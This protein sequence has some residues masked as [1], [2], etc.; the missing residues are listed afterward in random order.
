M[1]AKPASR[2]RK[3]RPAP[4]PPAAIGLQSSAVEDFSIVGIGASAGGLEAFTQFLQALP[5]DTGMAFVL[6]QHLEPSHTSLLSE[7]LTRTTT[8]AV[9][10]VRNGMAIAPNCVYVI[11][12]NTRMTLAD[13]HL[14]LE[15]RQRTQGKHL[16]I[17][18]F[19]TSLATECG[20]QAIAIVLSGSGDDGAIGIAAVKAAGG[21]TFA[22]TPTSAEFPTMPQN[23]IATGQVDFVLPPVGIAAELRRISHDPELVRSP[24]QES[25]AIVLVPNV[26]PPAS[27]SQ[28]FALLRNA[29]GV[30]FTHYKQ[31]TLRRRITRRMALCH[32]DQID[33][34]V[35][36]LHDHPIEV[37]SLYHDILINVTSFFREPASFEALKIQVFPQ[38]L[39]DQPGDGPIRIWIP[40][41]ATGEEAYSMAISLLE[42][43]ADQGIQ[44]TIQIFATDISEVA[45][46]EA[47]LG[48]YPQSRLADVSPERL[49][50]FFVPTDGGHQISKAVRELCVFACQDLTSD[51]PFSRLDLISCRNVLIY[52]EP[53]LQKKVMPIF[54]YAL[55]P[56]GYLIL[57]SSESI[58][59]FADLFAIADKK[60]RIYSRKSS[61][62]RLNFSFTSSQSAIAPL[63]PSGPLLTAAWSDRSLTQAADQIV[64][65][66]YAP[67]GVVI[68]ADLEIRQFRGQTSA[69]LEPAPGKASLNLL[70][71]ARPELALELRA[72]IY[73]AAQQ[74]IAVRHP[75]VPLVNGDACARVM[76]EVIPFGPP[77]GHDRY[78]LVLFESTPSVAPL[79]EPSP[80]APPVV[81]TQEIDRL[82]LELAGT[83]A[84]LQSIIESHEASNQE[85]KVANEEIL[86][87]NE[88]LQ[89][90]NEELET[91][92]E[93]IQATNEELSTINDELRSR[94]Q[95]LNYVN[96]DLHNLL[97][98]VNIPIL[99]LSGDLRIRRFT[100]MAETLF[101]LIP[102]DVGRRF[103]DIQHKLDLPN[104][105]ALAIGVI[106]T[107]HTH[108]QEVQDTSGHWYSL[109]IRPYK[110][111]DNQIDGAVIN[112]ID[113]DVLKRHATLI[114][115][116]R[117]YA[118]AIGDE[119]AV[120]LR[121]LRHRV[122]N[123]LQ[124]ISSLLSLQSSRTSD[125]TAIQILQDS[126]NR[127]QTIALMHEVLHRSPNLAALNFADYVKL[128]VSYVFSTG[129]LQ[130]GAI[131]PA[132]SVPADLPIHPDQ[133]VLCGLIINEL[134]TNALKYGAPP[135][136][137]ATAPS[138]SV[139]IAM[140]DRQLS[141]AVSNDG[142]TLP[143]DFDLALLPSIGLKLVTNLVEQL[144]GTLQ[145]DRGQQTTF[146]V[147]FS[148]VK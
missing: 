120:L 42:F 36:Y 135:A 121:E 8:M 70:K 30:D 94:N 63:A 134:V 5:V 21:I 62:T 103:S 43:L 116:S 86:S 4:P 66:R 98:S 47:R 9:H 131:A 147:C 65:Q 71:M 126:Q 127:V 41:C 97:S 125:A 2:Q 12:P 69:Y 128:L 112:L 57:G 85:L 81:L 82:N 106:D 1:A 118:T 123:N 140:L 44:T 114:E 89:S 91:A 18:A 79:L 122:K 77:Q 115:Q 72:T 101:N 61:P 54:H 142:D 13:R 109:R 17:D 19:F 64:L 16:P 25:S 75:G 105:A 148:T 40:G 83:K 100:P 24:V 27:L 137:D 129:N 88:E 58:G 15:P 87:S 124:V 46:A 117:D 32:I 28:V 95:Q 53:L 55:K 136:L 146:K 49:R 138:V 67:V 141:L 26:D 76:L 143:A 20:H 52:F 45:I 38:L 10:E 113:I 48:I 7:I 22:Q 11:P 50:R 14:V 51:P 39:L 78:F 133:A 104:L 6:I 73:Q 110:T 102:T 144:N 59:E 139:Q 23:A 145:I 34:Y 119:K 130:P 107:L 37:A 111:I 92:K 132:V 96:S 60:M 99:M 33:A 29:M 31:G 74:G 93:E 84:Y 108:E 3:S 90:T 56:A 80:S 35:Q 68:S